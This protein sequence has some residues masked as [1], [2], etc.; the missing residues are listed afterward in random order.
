MAA[1]QTRAV[2]SQLA[3]TI[4]FPSGE[5]WVDLTLA[6]CPFSVNKDFPVAASQT[7]AVL[8]WLAVTIRLPSS[9]KAAEWR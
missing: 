4:R 5:K 1:S 2:P 8:S 6:V 3:V 9:E 7:R